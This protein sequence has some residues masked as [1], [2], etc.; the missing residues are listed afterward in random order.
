MNRNDLYISFGKISD[1]LLERSEITL[2]KKHEWIKLCAAAACICF[3]VIVYSSV[4]RSGNKTGSQIIEKA[5]YSYSTHKS[6]DTV[7][8]G[9]GE[10]YPT[11]MVRGKLYEWHEGGAMYSQIPEGYI[12]Y[13]EINHISGKVPVNE[14]DFVSVFDAVGSI[15]ISND[16]NAIYIRMDADWLESTVIVRF[17]A[18]S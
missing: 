17:D 11:V 4:I 9:A 14:C 3:I 12:Y 18:V 1:D 15:Y 5:T 10:I 8:Y 6:S 2:H 7:P 13:D 16:E